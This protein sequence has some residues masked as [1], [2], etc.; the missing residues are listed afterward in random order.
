MEILSE[1]IAQ[2]SFHLNHTLLHVCILA[3]ENKNYTFT[4]NS[5]EVIL[6]LNIILN[7][8]SQFSS[9]LNKNV[10]F[11]F[12]KNGGDTI[13]LISDQNSLLEQLMCLLSLKLE[14]SLCLIIAV[15]TRKV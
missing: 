13:E 11:F 7:T 2:N 4:R 6:V 15:H 9:N 3:F 1:N 5:L 8:Q 10:I 12:Q 14:I